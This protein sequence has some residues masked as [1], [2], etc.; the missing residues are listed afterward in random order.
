LFISQ[1]SAEKKTPVDESKTEKK[2]AP[3]PHR[4]PLARPSRKQKSK[5]ATSS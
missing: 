1:K 2:V 4:P 5:E 3:T